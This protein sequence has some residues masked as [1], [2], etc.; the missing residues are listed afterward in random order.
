MFITAISLA[1][2]FCGYFLMLTFAVYILLKAG[3]STVAAHYAALSYCF[4]NLIAACIGLWAIE[5]QGRRK[6]TLRKHMTKFYAFPK[7]YSLAQCE[8]A[9]IV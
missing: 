4:V 1:V 3:L 9:K 2:P 8:C 7:L 6:M 5:R